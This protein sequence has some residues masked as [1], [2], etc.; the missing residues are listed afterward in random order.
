MT[1]MVLLPPVALLHVSCLGLMMIIV[2][3]TMK[4]YSHG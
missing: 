4:Y 1:K 3:C 2:H